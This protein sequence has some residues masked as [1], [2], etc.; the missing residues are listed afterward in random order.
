MSCQWQP[1]AKAAKKAEKWGGQGRN[2][3]ENGVLVALLKNGYTEKNCI[4]G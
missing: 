1:Q 2:V 4:K 3:R